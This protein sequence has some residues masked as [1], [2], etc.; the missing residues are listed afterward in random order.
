MLGTLTLMGSGEMTETMGKVHRQ[1]MNR[2]S[3]PVRPVFL[4]TPAGFQLNADELSQRATEY[5][6]KRFGLAIK[7]ASFKHAPLQAEA[8]ADEQA[9][10]AAELIDASNYIFAGPGS[11][12]YAARQWLTSPVGDALR[13]CLTR[14][15]HVVFASAAALSLSRYVVPVYE[16]YKVGQDPHWENGL[17]I[18][19]Q[20]GFELA[21]VPHWNNQEGGTH[22][23]RFAYLGEPRLE[24]MEALLP[25]S[26][27]I[28]G[29][30][31]YT[32]CTIDMELRNCHVGGIGT[33]TVRRDGRELVAQSGQ[34]FALESLSR[35]STAEWTPARTTDFW[36]SVASTTKRADEGQT[37]EE[38]DGGSQMETALVQML[39]DMRSELR[40]LG[41][42]DLADRIRMGLED[43]DVIIQD[44]RNETTWHRARSSD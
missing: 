35:G 26:A 43:R 28:L 41:Q 9:R 2:I 29:I 13:R 17:D 20:F 36:A 31:E 18:M 24:K 5:F 42:W 38:D 23:T 32:S 16:I 25:D 21:I 22:D 8:G 14:G 19:G 11:P 7:V 34:S 15:A 10:R 44:G 1:V 37:G 27:C 3:G 40:R 33:V 30:D 12:T 39:V 6:A 4:D